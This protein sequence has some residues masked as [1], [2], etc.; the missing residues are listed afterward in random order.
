[1]S[2][3]SGWNPELAEADTMIETLPPIGAVVQKRCT[4]GQ[5]AQHREAVHPRYRVVD[6]RPN[7]WAPDV[8]D[9]D[10]LLYGR[11]TLQRLDTGRNHRSSMLLLRDSYVIVSLPAESVLLVSRGGAS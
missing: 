10:A 4:C 3:R 7:K 8:H 9:D 11:V 5:P 2:E 6:I 1:M